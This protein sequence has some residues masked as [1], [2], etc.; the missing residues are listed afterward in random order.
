MNLWDFAG[1]FE[2]HFDMYQG[3]QVIFDEKA[4]TAK[5]AHLQEALT[6]CMSFVA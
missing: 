1:Q 4:K 3:N 2:G 5:L 6:D